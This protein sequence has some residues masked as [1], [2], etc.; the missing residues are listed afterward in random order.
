MFFLYG[1][2]K[3]KVKLNQTQ[4]SKTEQDSTES[5]ERELEM[6]SAKP[7]SCV[8][9]TVPTLESRENIQKKSTNGLISHKKF[10]NNFNQNC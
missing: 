8:F 5:H 4:R 9:R 2:F 7:K 3:D 6:R 10:V 1:L